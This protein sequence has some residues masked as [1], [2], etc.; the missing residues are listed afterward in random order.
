MVMDAGTGATS[1]TGQLAGSYDP[2]SSRLQS[3]G[4]PLGPGNSS[5]DARTPSSGGGLSEEEL[6]RRFFTGERR[7]EGG[8]SGPYDCW[9]EDKAPPEVG[10]C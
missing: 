2:A 10:S 5:S 4:A 6:E 1:A 3:L 7:G 8:G 9:V